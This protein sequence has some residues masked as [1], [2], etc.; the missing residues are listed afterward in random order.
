MINTFRYSKNVDT[1]TLK[2][3]GAFIEVII[4]H[5]HNSIEKFQ[6]NNQDVPLKKVFALIDTGASSSIIT[7][8]LAEELSLIQTGFRNVTSVNNQQRQAVYAG[9]IHFLWGKAKDIPLIACPL[10]GFDCLI[11]RD[12]LMHWHFTYNGADNT[13]VICD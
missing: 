11:G 2:K 12:I 5:P 7:P 4:T 9:S 6:E 10:K 1:D 3:H 13:V 8:V